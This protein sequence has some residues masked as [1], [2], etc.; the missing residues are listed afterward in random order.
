MRPTNDFSCGGPP[1]LPIDVNDAA[2]HFALSPLRPAVPSSPERERNPPTPRFLPDLA[3]LQGQGSYECAVVP[4]KRLMPARQSFVTD[5]SLPSMVSDK[6]PIFV[7][8]K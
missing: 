5:G 6:R 3:R 2:D 8:S 7:D 4:L 1:Q